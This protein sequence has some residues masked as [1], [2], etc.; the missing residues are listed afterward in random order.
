VQY[1]FLAVVIAAVLAVA[2]CDDDMSKQQKDKTW[3]AA[4][5]PPNDLAWPLSPPAG[6]V[7]RDAPLPPPTMSL[8]LLRRGQERYDIFCAPCHAPTG[9]GYGMIVQRGFPAPP[10]LYDARI[11]AEPTRH[12]YDVMTD[13]YGIMYSFAER[14][15]P[16]D[17]WAIA[18]YIRALQRTHSGELA[19][20]PAD[21]RAALQ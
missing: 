8:A 3:H 21:K 15:P 2:G 7:T 5:P 13:G 14:V 12:Y 6:L 17:R 1:R 4:T 18:A 9:D 11:V 10:P 20:V 16:R 19:E